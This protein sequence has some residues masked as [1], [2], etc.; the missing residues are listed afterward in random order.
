VNERERSGVRGHVGC[1]RNASSSSLIVLKAFKG[2][3]DRHKTVT[4]RY[5]NEQF[6][7]RDRHYCYQKRYMKNHPLSPI[8]E[9][10]SR[11]IDTRGGA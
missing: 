4:Y 7:L 1:E 5:D 2:L 11:K 9:S 3:K 10:S 8:L 6:S